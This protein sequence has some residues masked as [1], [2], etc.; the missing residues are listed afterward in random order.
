MS[1]LIREGF[2]E[3]SL[4]SLWLI[5]RD[6]NARG[7]RLFSSLGFDRRNTA[8]SRGGSPHSSHQAAHAAQRGGMAAQNIKSPE[9]SL[10][11]TF[12]PI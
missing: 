10:N 6:E 5:A 9:P 1:L 7:V 12:A 4:K 11:V 8:S 3:P 2:D